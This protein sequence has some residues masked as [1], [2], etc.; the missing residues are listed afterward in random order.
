MYK[1]KKEKK[2]IRSSIVRYSGSGSRACTGSEDGDTGPLEDSMNMLQVPRVGRDD[3]KC[4][5]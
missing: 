5:E 2:V 3:I 4:P 1:K